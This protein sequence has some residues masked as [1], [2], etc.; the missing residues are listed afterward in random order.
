MDIDMKTK[1]IMKFDK[2]NPNKLFRVKM[3]IKIQ[4]EN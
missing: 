1:D 3:L 4:K 2:K